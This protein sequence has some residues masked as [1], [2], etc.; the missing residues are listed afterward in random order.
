M[1]RI[2]KLMPEADM[3][4]A[5]FLDNLLKEK[6]DQQVNDFLMVYRSR[7]RD[8]QMTLLTALIGFLGIS[9]VHR[10]LLNQI[11]MGILYLFTAGLCFIGTIVDL[12]NHRTLTFE[13]NQKMAHEIMQMMR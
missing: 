6:S 12:V 3:E 13:Y 5:Y 1:E 11:G 4:E 10:F 7:R 2:Y 9:G 8:P